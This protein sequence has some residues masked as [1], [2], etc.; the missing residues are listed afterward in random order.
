MFFVSLLMIYKTDV[1]SWGGWVGGGGCPG[2]DQNCLLLSMVH[3]DCSYRPPVGAAKTNSLANVTTTLSRPT[4]HVTNREGEG[5][6]EASL[7]HD[8]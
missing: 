7:H 4:G 8:C 5:L 2:C 3:I 6:S 1:T